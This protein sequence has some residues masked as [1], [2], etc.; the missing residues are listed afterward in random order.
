MKYIKALVERNGV[1]VDWII[2]TSILIIGVSKATNIIATS[3]AGLGLIFGVVIML[4][5]ALWTMEFIKY[6]WDVFA[7]GAVL[8]FL[9]LPFLSFISVPIIMYVLGTWTDNWWEMFCRSIFS[10]HKVIEM[11]AAMPSIALQFIRL[12]DVRACTKIH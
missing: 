10:E 4:T 5:A 1:I 6:R 3:T 12:M 9:L 7:Q 11:I 8:A 2:I